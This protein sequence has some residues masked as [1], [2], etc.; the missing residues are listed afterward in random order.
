[1]KINKLRFCNI[2]SFKGT[3]EIDFNAEPLASSGLFAITGPTGSGK[4]TILDALC[5]SLYGEIPRYDRVT[6]TR[7]DAEG[8]VITHFAQECFVETHYEVKDQQ[9]L[10]IWRIHKSTRSDKLQAP[11]MEL[12]FVENKE[13]ISSKLSEV[14]LENQNIIGLSYDQF[15]RSIVLTQGD[16]AKF[17]KADA[18]DR[19]RLLENIT[20]AHIYRKIGMEVFERY[21]KLATTY[22]ELSAQAHNIVILDS[23]AQLSIQDAIGTNNEAIQK[24]SKSLLEKEEILSKLSLRV[25]KL[26]EFADQEKI[27]LS[28]QEEEDALKP[29]L[30]LLA[31]HRKL[32]P[33]IIS[34]LTLSAKV[35]EMADNK[36]QLESYRKEI[37]AVNQNKNKAIQALSTL[38]KEELNDENYL[39]AMRDFQSKVNIANQKLKQLSDDGK[40]AAEAYKV[41]LEKFPDQNIATKLSSLKREEQWSIL[42]DI[43]DQYSFSKLEDPLDDTALQNVMND[44]EAILGRLKDELNVLKEKE[45]IQKEISEIESN[46]KANELEILR[47]AKV[48]ETNLS[49]QKQ[50]AEAIEALRNQIEKRTLAASFEEHRTLLVDGEP[51]PLC[52]SIHHPY[53]EG[54]EETLGLHK[55]KVELDLLQTNLIRIQ[56][57]VQSIQNLKSSKEGMQISLYDRAKSIQARLV[58]LSNQQLQFDKVSELTDYIGKQQESLVLFKNEYNRRN[59]LMHLNY[60]LPFLENC[61]QLG[62]EY[63]SILQ[64]RNN[65]YNGEE[66]INQ[67]LDS[68]QNTISSAQGNIQT[69]M[70]SI[71]AKNEALDLIVHKIETLE[72]A[73][74]Q[75][76]HQLGYSNMDEAMGDVLDDKLRSEIIDAEHSISTRVAENFTITDR[77]KK[78]IESIQDIQLDIG[79]DDLQDQIRHL[80]SE[81]LELSR[82]NGGL[83]NQLE[84]DDQNRIKHAEISKALEEHKATMRPWEWLA[85]K[86]GDSTGNTYA[87]Y[88][89]NLSL[90]TLIGLANERLKSLSDRYVLEYTA[91]DTDLRIIDMYQGNS[92]RSIKTLSGGE[93]FL[94]SLAL[95]LSLSDLASQNVKLD[96]LFI[97][98]GFGTLDSDTLDIALCT[99]ER[100]QSES[101]RMIGIISHVESLKERITTQIKVMRYADGSSALETLSI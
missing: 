54:K 75:P 55:E 39:N 57:E 7:I 42:Q 40:M 43:I 56:Q 85:G 60:L 17:L 14:P 13:I 100:L 28:L 90:Q 59:Y 101:H 69:L 73:L 83:N 15:V 48:C 22:N 9:Y 87:K 19:A 29:K 52:G 16:F 47:L 82:Q 84:L 24:L 49:L 11:S 99:L 1:M 67:L 53:A 12:S 65:L 77:I 78:E 21:K 93:T 36:Q 30:E 80:K 91:I 70:G 5:L 79:L 89:Q 35:S 51:C 71:E 34:I 46:L 45:N 86:I 74:K 72:A 6:N 98:E 88:A 95:A 96:C 26:A 32:E 81:Q 33:Y 76:L 97:D 62:R 25:R 61:L 10:S 27:R 31:K 37:I 38:V 4:S 58:E 44:S 23:D 92:S 94:L 8:S 64:Q 18:N 68:M 2:H 63:N 41:Q 3:H 50:T 20:G 66:E